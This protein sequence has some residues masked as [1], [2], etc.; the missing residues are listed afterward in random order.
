MIL[1]WYNFLQWD[2]T[3]SKST[4]VNPRH[5]ELWIHAFSFYTLSKDKPTIFFWLSYF[6]KDLGQQSSSQTEIYLKSVNSV[7]CLRMH[8]QFAFIMVVFNSIPEKTWNY[9]SGSVILFS[10]Q[11][12]LA[13]R[14]SFWYTDTLCNN[15]LSFLSDLGN[16]MPQMPTKIIW[17][18]PSSCQSLVWHS[19][20]FCPGLSKI[21]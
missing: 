9:S 7:M 6:M 2:Y 16:P 5:S 10:S 12:P 18:Q 8:G 3:T 15:D 13:S 4:A 17:F 21:L 1:V 20:H 19:L 14:C 11:I